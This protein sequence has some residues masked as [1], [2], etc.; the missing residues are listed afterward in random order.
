[1]AP[2]TQAEVDSVM[3]E[4]GPMTAD[5]EKRTELGL[6]VYKALFNAK[7]DYITLFTKL[8]GLTKDNV[9]Q[10]DGIKYY[11][12]TYVEDLVKF[13]QAAAKDPELQALIETSIQQ[14]KQRN[15]N[16]EQFLMAPVFLY[17]A[18]NDAAALMLRWTLVCKARSDLA[19]AVFTHRGGRSE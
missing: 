17:S 7:P 3:Q 18:P 8:Q 14:H 16:K 1:M 10:S 9:M 6:K 2:L 12:R 4:L 5:A 19:R 11:G 15:V 13:I